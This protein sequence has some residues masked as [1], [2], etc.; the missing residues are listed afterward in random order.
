MR[1]QFKIRMMILTGF[2]LGLLSLMQVSFAHGGDIEVLEGGAKGPVHLTSEQA[3][4]LDIKVVQVTNRPMA[5]LLGLNGQI[6]LLP[7]AQADVSIRISGSVTA[8]DV[9]LGDSVKAGQRLATVQSRLVGNPP[10]SVAVNAPI[11]G[12]IDARNISLGQAV[13]PNTVLFHISNRDKL[14]VVAQ[15]Y[16]EDLGKVKVGQEVNIHALSYPKQTFLGQVTL[17][18]PN[19]DPMTRTVNVRI[20]LDNREGLLKPGMFVRANL[21]LTHNKAA[22]VVPNAALLQAD[23][24]QFVFVQNENTYKRVNVKIGAVEDDYSEIIEG[25]VPGDLVVTQGNRELYTLWLSGG[26]IQQSGQEEH[27]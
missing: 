17:I 3:R 13:E 1:L 2:F 18:E 24:E 16:E 9:N 19:L 10:P 7:D 20:T 25:L 15:V 23:N 6:Q 14:L 5:Q 26:Q 4:M 21:I 22:L 11:A 27:H 12:I 8:I